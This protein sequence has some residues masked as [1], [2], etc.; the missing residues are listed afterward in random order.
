[1]E[2]LSLRHHTDTNTTSTESSGLD[3][4]SLTQ[5]SLDED[6]R[7]HPYVSFEQYYQ[8]IEEARAAGLISESQL[9]LYK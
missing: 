8:A 2:D 9:H 4:P 3:N 7:I 5:F 1:M 6:G